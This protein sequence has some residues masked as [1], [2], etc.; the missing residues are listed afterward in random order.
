MFV[1]LQLLN[2]GEQGEKNY[3]QVVPWMESLMFS[4]SESDSQPGPGRDTEVRERER[5]HVT[6]EVVSS[7]SSCHPYKN[8]TQL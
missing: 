8:A 5:D 6:Q 7:I 2:K 1:S 3:T 4:R